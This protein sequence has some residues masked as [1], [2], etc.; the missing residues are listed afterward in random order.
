MNGKG[1]ITIKVIINHVKSKM[2]WKTALSAATGFWNQYYRRLHAQNQKLHKLEMLTIKKFY[3]GVEKL[4][5]CLII[6]YNIV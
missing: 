2:P 3:S 6:V 4:E 5:S 1:S